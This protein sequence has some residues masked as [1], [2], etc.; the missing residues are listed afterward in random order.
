[1]SNM[2]RTKELVIL[3]IEAQ[4][5]QEKKKKEEIHNNKRT[6]KT[7]SKMT[8]TNELIMLSQWI[9][10]EAGRKRWES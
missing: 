1:M 6:K 9:S 2:T 10:N 4:K 7:V 5:R 3:N 8:S